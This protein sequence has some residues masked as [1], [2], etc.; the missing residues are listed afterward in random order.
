MLVC[1]G[2]Y[3]LLTARW[4]K[5]KMSPSERWSVWEERWKGM[6]RVQKFRVSEMGKAECFCP[7]NQDLKMR[8]KRAL[9]NESPL[10]N[11]SYR[12]GWECVPKSKLRFFF[13]QLKVISWDGPQVSATA[14]KELTVGG[15]ERKAKIWIRERIFVYGE[16]LMWLF[17]H[18][19]FWK[20]IDEMAAQYLWEMLLPITQ[21][22]VFKKPVTIE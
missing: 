3:S 1:V 11:L 22:P 9:R 16:A 2:F 5:R 7:L 10:G 8:M 20:Q 17:I 19:I 12:K 21:Q 14:V 6:E 13:F 15:E 4:E 18:G